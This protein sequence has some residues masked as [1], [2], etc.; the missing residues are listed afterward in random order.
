[1]VSTDVEEEEEEEEEIEEE[2]PSGGE[3]GG[4]YRVLRRNPLCMQ[5]GALSYVQGA[6]EVAL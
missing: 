4:V 2:E 6:D 3:D 5:H 1:M